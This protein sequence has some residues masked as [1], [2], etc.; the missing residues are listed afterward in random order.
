MAL[1]SLGEIETAPGAQRRELAA[2]KREL[3]A[4]LEKAASI[5]NNAGL[6]NARD[7]RVFG[8]RAQLSHCFPPGERAVPA[9]EYRSR[10]TEAGSKAGEHFEAAHDQGARAKAL[11]KEARM[12]SFVA[13]CQT[14]LGKFKIR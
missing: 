6:S 9:H 5:H 8:T 11:R 14:V 1:N 7:A 4:A 2:T 10:S 12:D 3:A 13:A